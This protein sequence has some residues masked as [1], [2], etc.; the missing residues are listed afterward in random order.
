MV[1]GLAVV[2]A[3]AGTGSRMRARVNKPFLMLH[4]RPVLAYSLDLFERSPL[5]KEVVIVAHV[6]EID[7][8]K[9][10]VVKKFGFQ[11]VHN[12]VAGGAT[13]QESVGRG[14]RTIKEDT[15]FVAV[16]DGARPLLTATLLDELYQAAVRWGA[17]V[18][19]I[20]VRD[21]LKTIEK[22]DFVGKTLDRSHIIAIQTPQV[23][24]FTALQQAYQM[25][26]DQQFEA[27]DD[28]A[29]FERYIGRVRIVPGNYRNLKI[30]TP[31]DLIIAEC[32]LN[33]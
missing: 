10:E 11:K 8:C 27:T 19:G 31:E 3:A 18:P 29:L 9:T 21:T 26:R 33:Q 4:S 20:P 17:A 28:A 23:F 2:I 12:V 1:D 32:F 13:R 14:L 5:V 16:H 25:A 30:T 7:Y 6:Q 15:A 24:G 22:D